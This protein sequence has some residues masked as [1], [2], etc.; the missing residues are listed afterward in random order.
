M[1]K[2]KPASKVVRRKFEVKS[3]SS[4]RKKFEKSKLENWTKEKKFNLKEKVQFEVKS[5]S[6]LLIIS[7]GLDW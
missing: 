3:D 5:S 2:E 6:D 4:E 1:Y 7:K